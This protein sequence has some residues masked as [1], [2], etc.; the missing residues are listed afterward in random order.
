MYAKGNGTW[1]MEGETRGGR[2][3]RF[4]N[5]TKITRF[6][7]ADCH[8]ETEHSN[9][10]QS[11]NSPTSGGSFNFLR[12]IGGDGRKDNEEMA[13]LSVFDLVFEK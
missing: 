9:S 11:R 10:D 2:S 12:R 8:G 13:Y 7:K 6:Q 5:E 3:C 4:Y 1:R